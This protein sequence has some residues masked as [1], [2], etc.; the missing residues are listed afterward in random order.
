[1]MN[2][3]KITFAQ[4]DQMRRWVEFFRHVNHQQEVKRMEEHLRQEK[5][6]LQRLQSNDPTKGQNVDLNA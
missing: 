2:I 4:L 3:Q 5:L 1:M 6:R